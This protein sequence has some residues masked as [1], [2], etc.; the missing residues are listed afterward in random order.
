MVIM[1]TQS[2]AIISTTKSALYIVAIGL[3]A[4]IGAQGAVMYRYS[5][6]RRK[7]RR[8]S[9]TKFIDQVELDDDD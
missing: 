8:G 2:L 3:G 9:K 1:V 5:N 4:W 7:R 6:H